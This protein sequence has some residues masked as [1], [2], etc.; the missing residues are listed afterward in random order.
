M[1]TMINS[2]FELNLVVFVL[3]WGINLRVVNLNLSQISI[4]KYDSEYISKNVPKEIALIIIMVKCILRKTT[5]RWKTAEDR[6]RL[7]RPS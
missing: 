2:M 3:F 7:R 4:S 1:N 5:C 6:K